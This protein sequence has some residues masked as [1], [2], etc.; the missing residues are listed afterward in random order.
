MKTRLKIGEFAKL[1]GITVKT[2]LYYHKIGLLSEPERSSG[3][4]RLYGVEELN[5]VLAVKRLKNLG[6]NLEQIRGILGCAEE[7]PTTR[8]TLLSLQIELE[9]QIQAL[10][11][12]ADRIQ[13]LFEA[14]HANLREY[15]KESQFFKTFLDILGPDAEETYKSHCP[16]LYN[17]EKQLFGLMDDLQWGVDYQVLMREV[18]EYFKYHP[19]QYQLSLDYGAQITAIASLSPNSPVIEELARNYGEYIISLPIFNKL[20]AQSSNQN[21]TFEPLLNEMFGEVLTAAQMRFIE[22]LRQF[23]VPEQ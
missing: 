14:E 15:S 2:V 8:S 1:N 6:L 20:F 13:K 9:A 10:Q 11:E 18:A 3:G 5:R 23:I 21:S 16:E 4:Y 22:L 17:Q 19:D 12:R 7:H